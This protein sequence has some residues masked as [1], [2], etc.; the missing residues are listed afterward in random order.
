MEVQIGCV[1]LKIDNMNTKILMV[2][3]YK[4]LQQWQRQ[5][6]ILCFLLNAYCLK[7]NT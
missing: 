6:C 5:F 3:W 7:H 2:M 4:L 1:I